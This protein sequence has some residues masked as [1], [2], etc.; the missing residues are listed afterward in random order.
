M[1]VNAPARRQSA[2]GERHGSGVDRGAAGIR[3]CSRQ[4]PRPRTSL[5]DLRG[6]RAPKSRGERHI[7]ATLVESDDSP[8]A[9]YKSTRNVVRVAAG[10]LKCRMPVQR[11][12]ASRAE[13]TAD[14]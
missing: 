2:A 7:V 11:D 13:S 4:R 3:V 5:D 14:E 10:P 8:A 12:S 9:E 1:D 6:A